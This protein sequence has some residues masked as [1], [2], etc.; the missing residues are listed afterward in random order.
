MEE[1]VLQEKEITDM[2]L[3]QFTWQSNIQLKG[4][5]INPQIFLKTIIHKNHENHDIYFRYSAVKF[6]LQAEKV[7]EEGKVQG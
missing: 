1:N 2:F 4:T 5:V 6:S 3:S 7:K